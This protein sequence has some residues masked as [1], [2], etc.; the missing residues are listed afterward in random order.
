MDRR[1][2]KLE[3]KKKKRDLAKKKAKASASRREDPALLLLRAAARSPFGPCA[4]SKHWNAEEETPELV[5]IIVSR[6][7]P[8]GDLVP[9]SALVDRTCLGIKSAFPGE[10]VSDEELEDLF[11][12]VGE[13]H[14]GMERCEPLVAQS[15]VYHAI[16]YARDLGFEPDPDFPE[17]LS[18][19]DR[20]S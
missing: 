5:S 8:D 1:Q 6:R 3:Q 17:L 7:L 9:G 13:P 2:R 15:V 14:G 20:P 19:R 4:I 10:K 16:D 18:A 12:R 11:D